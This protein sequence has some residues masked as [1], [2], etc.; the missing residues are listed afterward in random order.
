MTV[1]AEPNRRNA[2]FAAHVPDL[3]YDAGTGL[4]EVV[5]GDV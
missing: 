4:A 3:G 2:E 1:L 5:V